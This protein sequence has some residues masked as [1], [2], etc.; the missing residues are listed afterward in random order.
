M[1]CAELAVP[2]C[3]GPFSFIDNSTPPS[4]LSPSLLTF[5]AVEP[6][7]SWPITLSMKFVD[8]LSFLK[9]LG[10]FEDDYQ[11]FIRAL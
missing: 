3:M 5:P 2:S 6:G 10:V 8:H 7:I 4:S 1:A 9:K 11:H